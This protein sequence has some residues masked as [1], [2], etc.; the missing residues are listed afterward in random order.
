MPRETVRGSDYNFVPIPEGVPA[1][2]EFP[3]DCRLSVV[4]VGWSKAP[5]G[6]V[7]IGTCDEVMLANLKG[8]LAKAILAGANPLVIVDDFFAHSAGFWVNLDWDGCNELIR[9]VRKARDDAF[10]KAE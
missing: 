10:G 6:S 1:P 9:R 5:T 8:Q 7:E 2:A 4:E 3:P